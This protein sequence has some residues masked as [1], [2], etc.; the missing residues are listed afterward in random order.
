MAK[1]RKKKNVKKK[2]DISF[3]NVFKDVRL[4]AGFAIVL[5][6][7]GS[8][9]GIGYL[10][11]NSPFF[12]IK[13]VHVIGGVEAEKLKIGKKAEALYDF[14]NIFTV[15]LKNAGSFLVKEVPEIKQ[16]EIRRRMPDTL[17]IEVLI[18]EPVAF[19]A[20]GRGIVIDREGIV[21]SSELKGSGD[22]ILVKGIN[23]FLRTPRSGEVVRTR[24]IDK[25]LLLIDLIKRK[26]IQKRHR[27]KYI[28]ISDLDNIIVS[29][30]NV[31]VKMGNDDFQ[32]KINRLKEILEDPAIDAKGIGYIDLRFEDAVISPK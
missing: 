15:D 16:I 9:A 10:F 30:D 23:F 18:R 29:V 24:A 14:R 27:V 26:N 20:S 19:I 8:I 2:L 1:T 21:L 11:L 7:A 4:A 17:E 5:L 25:A 32:W 3:L 6:I 12:E 13:E 28:D 31:V 22:L